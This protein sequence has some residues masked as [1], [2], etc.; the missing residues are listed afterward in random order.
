MEFL[1]V[2]KI[3]W[4]SKCDFNCVI[5]ASIILCSKKLQRTSFHNNVNWAIISESSVIFI[6]LFCF[7]SPLS[8]IYLCACVYA[9][10]LF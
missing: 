3:N 10:E 1:K 7:A 2:I 9:W 6:S 4:K 8:F 5:K